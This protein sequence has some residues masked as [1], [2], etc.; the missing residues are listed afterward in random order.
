MRFYIFIQCR[1]LTTG[2]IC[3]VL[4]FQLLR[5]QESFAVTGYEIFGFFPVSLGKMNYNSLS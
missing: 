5:E 4:G 2:V 3:S 1:Y